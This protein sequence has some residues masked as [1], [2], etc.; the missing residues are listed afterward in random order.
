MLVEFNEKDMQ[1]IKK[2]DLLI[3]NGKQFEPV[4]KDLLLRS[5]ADELEALKQALDVAHN[6]IRNHNKEFIRLN[7]KFDKFI[8]IFKGD[9][10]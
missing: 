3:Y 10:K 9:K 7:A 4:S 8:N 5:Q 2:G 6:G 1:K